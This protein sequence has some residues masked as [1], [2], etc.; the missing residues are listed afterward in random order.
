MSNHENKN[1]EIRNRRAE[2]NEERGWLIFGGILAC[3]GIGTGIYC[4]NQMKRTVRIVNRA[5]STVEDLSVV[6]VQQDIVDRAVKNAV[7]NRVNDAVSSAAEREVRKQVAEVVKRSE[8]DIRSKVA[9]D[10]AKVMSDVSADDIYDDISELVKEKLVDH[11]EDWI[12]DHFDD[13]VKDHQ[14]TVDRMSWTYDN[15][16]RRMNK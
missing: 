16:A 11:L 12:D 15:F 13:I 10:I 8:D 3:V 7:T 4:H 2:R 1:Q 14:R 9:Q 5:A 6:N